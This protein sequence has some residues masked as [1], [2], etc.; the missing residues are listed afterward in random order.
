MRW[1]RAFPDA[2]GPALVHTLSHAGEETKPCMARLAA[3]VLASTATNHK[4]IASTGRHLV[5]AV[6]S[7]DGAL[8]PLNAKF[9]QALPNA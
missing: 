7:F 8:S 1:T 9:G 3:L 4:K 5:S 6:S 2:L